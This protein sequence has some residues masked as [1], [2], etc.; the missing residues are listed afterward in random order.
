MTE[1]GARY[2]NRRSG[3]LQLVGL[4]NGVVG[5]V[6]AALL[7]NGTERNIGLDSAGINVSRALGPALAGLIIA[8]WGLAAPFWVNAYTTLGV[9][10]AL[11]WWRPKQN[12]SRRLPAERLG[13]AMRIGLRYAR[14]N[15]H[16]ISTLVHAAAFFCLA[17]AYWALKANAG[18]MAPMTGKSSRT[19]RLRAFSSKLSMSI[20]GST[21]CASTNA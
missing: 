19:P 1:A 9:I 5:L 7:V 20:R 14:H 4:G 18:A 2:T 11:V 17:S 3:V 10:A 8:L 12:E 21:I 16:L 13:S 15:P 6:V